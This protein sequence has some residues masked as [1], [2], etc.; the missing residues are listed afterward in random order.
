MEQGST[1][2]QR[3]TRGAGNSYREMSNMMK[4]LGALPEIL[5]WECRRLTS[6]ELD[7]CQHCGSAFAG[8]TG[9]AYRSGRIPESDSRARADVRSGLRPRSLREI[10]EDLQRVRDLAGS[11]R[12]PPRN[13][14]VSLL[15]YQ[16]P[17]CGRFVSQAA[18]ECVCGVRF[19]PPSEVT[20]QCPE[21][22]SNITSGRDECPVCGVEFRA[23]DFQDDY[24][25]ACPRCGTHVESDAIRC[26]CGAWFEA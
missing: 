23:A 20:F 19:A 6:F 4:S 5:C 9:G 15:L 13:E 17:A 18:E 24:V 12:E 16:C 8:N 3:R 22:A 25:F 11:P 7:R 2:M 21:C 10:V 26:S 1:V 14:E